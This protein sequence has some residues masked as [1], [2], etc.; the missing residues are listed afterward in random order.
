MIFKAIKLLRPSKSVEVDDIPGFEIKGCT[1]IFL[2]VLKYIFNLS[3][4]QQYF[5]TLWKLVAIVLVLKKKQ[6]CLC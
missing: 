2:P 5:P 1:D 4:S 3:L 6:Q